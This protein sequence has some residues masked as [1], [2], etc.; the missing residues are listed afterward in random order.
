MSPEEALKYINGAMS[1]RIPQ[2]KSLSLFADYLQSPAGQMLLS[3]MKKDTQASTADILRESKAY[4]QHIAEAIEYQ[5]FERSFPAFTFALATG[6]G[7]TRLMGAFVA[8][9]YLVYNVQ[10]FLIVAPNLTIYRKL[11]DD[12]SKANNPK[13]VF[14]GIQEININTAKVVTTDNYANQRGN[15]LFGNQIEINIFNIQQFAQKDMTN[16]RG[17]T[18]AWETAGESYFD[19]LK[20]HDDLV[21]M[22]DEAH[23]YHADAA[24]VALDVLDPLFGLEMTATPYLGTQGSGKNL[25]QIRMKNVLYA[26]NLG[27]AIRGKLV[28]D[29]WVGTEADVDFSRFDPDSIETDARKLQLAVFFHERAKNALK[30]YALENKKQ[31]VKPVLLV[32]AKDTTHAANLRALLD[33]ENF[34]GGEFMGKVIEIH[35]KLKGNEADENI[36]KLISLEHPDNPIE[37][38]IH[39]NMLKEGWDVTNVYTIAPLRESAALILTEQTIGRGLR[40]PYG[41]RTGVALV[42]RLVIVAHEQYSKVVTLA[43]DST[44]IQGNVEQVSEQEA[45]EIKVFTE[46][47]PLVVQN[48]A[49]DI[50]QNTVVM[51]AVHKKATDYVLN[52]PRMGNVAE[53]VLEKM[54]ET[55]KEEMVGLL[56][57]ETIQQNSVVTLHHQEK[58]IP[59]EIPFEADTL[60]G[61]MNAEAKEELNKIGKKSG[62]DT[63]KHHISIPRL[64]L[65][66]N[67]GELVILDFELDTSIM[68]AY[69][70]DRSILEEQLQNNREKDLF[71][72]EVPGRR[73]TEITR[74]TSFGNN[75]RQ[76]PESTI[77]AALLDY[78]LTDY[79]DLSQRPLLL[80]L[81]E[82]ATTHYRKKAVDEDNLALIIESNVRPIADDIYKQILMN[83]VL[84]SEGYLESDVRESKPYLE[85]YNISLSYGTRAVMLDS[86]ID[87]FS[88]KLV[89]GPFQK[90]CHSMYRFDSSDEV[91]LAYIVDRDNSVEDW[92]RPAPKQFDGLYWRDAEGESHHR[93]EPDFVVETEREIVMIEVKPQAEIDT[94]SVQAKKQTADKY[95]EIVN[96]NIDRYGIQKPWRYVILA[97][98]RITVRSTV[99]GLLQ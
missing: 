18:K 89:Y 38:V 2:A 26:Y 87:T 29:P 37:I 15:S 94:Q 32:V 6:V 20:G 85:Q 70:N 98:D 80:K 64:I 60:F 49:N 54:V 27:D 88:A 50:R 51:E 92:L 23:H 66:P 21:V 91:R 30:E 83:K 58:E 19:Y 25:R 41:E 14:K 4:F 59:A 57:K 81:A 17:I 67:Y 65:T 56:S 53:N 84:T 24:L 8:Y 68:Q 77:I 46:V 79:D 1:L 62:E 22:L 11:F 9:M 74:V 10:H 47:Q 55:K 12:F 31:V 93:Y 71:G 36:E 42:D 16:E 95:C 76:T 40:L 5:E 7:K 45:K 72:E 39:V 82:Q 34:R 63:K 44:L 90:A 69:P 99:F 3:R 61:S 28:K 75:K 43:K 97:T 52:L 73:M 13:Y 96:R 35:T 48:V 86:Q 78:P 33:S